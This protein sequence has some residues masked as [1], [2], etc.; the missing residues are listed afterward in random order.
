[1]IYKIT[2]IGLKQVNSNITVITILFLNNLTV[3][4]KKCSI[5]VYGCWYNIK[6]TFCSSNS[7]IFNLSSTSFE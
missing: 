2:G 4:K 1:M 7:A 6:L 3:N 5:I